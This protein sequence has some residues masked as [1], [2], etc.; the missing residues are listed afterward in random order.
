MQSSGGSRTAALRGAKAGQLRGFR[1]AAGG[2]VTQRVPKSASATPAGALRVPAGVAGVAPR[3]RRRRNRRGS[4]VS[5]QPPAA[6]PPLLPPSLWPTAAQLE[7]L[8]STGLAALPPERAAP[9]AQ[10]S[11]PLALP[12]ALLR[13]LLRWLLR[14]LE[15]SGLPLEGLPPVGQR[16]RWLRRLEARLRRGGG[17]AATLGPPE[18][19]LLGGLLGLLLVRLGHPHPRLPGGPEGENTS[20]GRS[21]ELLDRSFRLRPG[22][23]LRLEL[24]PLLAASPPTWLP[25]L[26]Q[27]LLEAGAGPG[28]RSLLPLLV[29]RGLRPHYPSEAPLL[30]TAEGFGAAA[31]P[32]LAPLGEGLLGLLLLPLDRWGRERQRQEWRGQQRR[33]NPVY[34]RLLYLRQRLRKE[35]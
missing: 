12:E 10:S 14:R 34:S 18:L 15:E 19:L 4:P 33:Q 22:W 26:Q 35:N 25:P 13:W 32:P 20:L 1:T 28:L 23:Y 9:L 30:E 24:E 11:A 21:L 31:P 2:P 7:L 17:D 29:Q 5:T 8:L 3:Q 16:G 6:E 27:R